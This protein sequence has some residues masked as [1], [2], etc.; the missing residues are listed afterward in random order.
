M[1]DR[2]S[3][4]T[5]NIER[6]T[7]DRGDEQMNYGQRELGYVAQGSILAVI[8]IENLTRIGFCTQSTT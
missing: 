6:S 3:R 8:V 2:V 5:E 4:V 7:F 1:H